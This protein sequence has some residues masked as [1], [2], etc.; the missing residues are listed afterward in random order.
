MSEQLPERPSLQFLKK[1]AKERLHE[2]R[3]SNPQTK[4]SA[5]QLAVA[6]TYGYSSWRALKAA[7]EAQRWTP[8]HEA[9]KKGDLAAVRRLL[10]AGVDANARESGD[11]T[12]P[13]HWAAAHRHLDVVRALL[14]AGCDVN[15]F[16]DLH[17]LDAIGW[18]TCFYPTGG[19]RGEQPE[20]AALLVE[21]GARHH[22]FSAMSLGDVELVKRV[23]ADNPAALDRRLSKYDGGLTPLDFALQLNRPDLAEILI[24]EGA[25]IPPR[26][27]AQD[28]LS[29]IEKLR[30]SVTCIRPM[31]YVDEIAA[32]LDWYKSIGFREVSRF[33]DEGVVNFGIVCLGEAEIL[34]NMNAS[35]ERR[36][37][38]SVSL[39]LNT[40]KATE[41]YQL[42]MSLALDGR[43]EIVEPIN[44]TFYGARQFAIRDLNGYLLFFIQEL[45]E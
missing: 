42:Y 15:G 6:R 18:A 13:L 29:G 16:G 41:L 5:A 35:G 21:H 38:Q 40:D 10:A 28:I 32:T 26:I 20:A 44:D 12:T 33:E 3:E 27:P 36:R 9:A 31:I 23:I 25:P 24:A 22:I 1:L 37:E 39:W 30:K 7:V 8:L 34:V 19:K 11:N 4:L 43:V 14:D 2:L 17:E 45:N